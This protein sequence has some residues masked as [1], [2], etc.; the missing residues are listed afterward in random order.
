MSDITV[1]KLQDVLN[2]IER[3]A[4][5]GILGSEEITRAYELARELGENIEKLKAENEK[6][7][8]LAER[9]WIAA[10]MLCQAWE[11][12]CS[13]GT[14]STMESCPLDGLCIYGSIQRDMR[15]LGFEVAGSDEI[16]RWI[17]EM[18]LEADDG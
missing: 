10:E 7:R 17:D 5:E 12:P 16:D 4:Y 1:T 2:D 8:G 11:G 6:L 3:N 13:A 18:K 9:E 14:A 15:E